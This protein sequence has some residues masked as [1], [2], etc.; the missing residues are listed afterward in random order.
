MEKSYIQSRTHFNTSSECIINLK[1]FKIT[2]NANFYSIFLDFKVLKHF[3][4][5]YDL[6]R[7]ELKPSLKLTQ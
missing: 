1:H 5:I 2:A 6:I 7:I 4:D 3:N